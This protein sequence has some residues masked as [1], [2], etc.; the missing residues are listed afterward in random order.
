MGAGGENKRAARTEIRGKKERLEQVRS[1]IETAERA[2]DFAKAAELKYAT[3]AQLEKEVV[4]AELKLAELQRR[5]KMV[6]E[7][8][9]PEDIAEVVGKWT[10]IPVTKLLEGEV[11]K[12][13]KMEE[14][15]HQ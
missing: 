3:Q 9:T 13:L 14:R 6:T 15:L 11:G 12:L 7:E 1:D 10:G 8:V 2:A 5:N 4:A